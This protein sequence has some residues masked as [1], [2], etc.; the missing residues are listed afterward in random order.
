M[1]RLMYVPPGCSISRKRLGALCA[2]LESRMGGDGN[3]I[4]GVLRGE[5]P[6]SYVGAKSDA[7]KMG[8]ML[9]KWS[10]EGR[11]GVFHTRKRTHG[12]VSDANCM[13]FI[14][15]GTAIAHNGCW[16]EGG[17]I[18]TACYPG[19][20]DSRIFAQLWAEKGAKWLLNSELGKPS[21]V[22]LLVGPNRQEARVPT[23]FFSDMEF[24]PDSRIWASE[25]PA[26]FRDSYTVTAGT[27]KLHIDGGEKKPT[28][29]FSGYG[30]ASPMKATATAAKPKGKG[31]G[32]GKGKRKAPGAI[33]TKRTKPARNGTLIELPREITDFP[34]ACDDTGRPEVWAPEW[35]DRGHVFGVDTL[36][37]DHGSDSV[38]R[39]GSVMEGS[40]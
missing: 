28:G 13:P 16:P 17:A 3:G 4:A 10:Q 11:H 19:F 12:E 14:A 15:R 1:C 29:A 38:Y 26:C 8:R 21:G 37:S 35:P 31:K 30:F 18:A 5:E 24:D 2:F 25:F 32:K 39:D 6:L 36:D 34:S 23:G 22:W 9:W 40:E 7:Q 33:T 20:S 27:H